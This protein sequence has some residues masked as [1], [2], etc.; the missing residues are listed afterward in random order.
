MILAG[1]AWKFTVSRHRWQSANKAFRAAKTLT[2]AP[3][4]AMNFPGDWGLPEEREKS[5]LE[6]EQKFSGVNFTELE[7]RL[8]Q[9]GASLLGQQVEVDQYLN[10][11]DRDFAITKEAFRL[12]RVGKDAVLTYKGPKHPG[13]VKIRTELEVF[14]ADGQDS[15]DDCLTLLRCLGY[16]PVAV[17]RKTRRVFRIEHDG[18]SISVCLDDVGDVGQFAEIEVLAPDDR[19][20]T[21][22]SAVTGMAVELGLQQLERRSYLSLYLAKTQKGSS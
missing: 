4:L 16:R 2:L 9:L 3:C 8:Y 7:E 15:A 14:L 18:L 12:R 11:P 10:A 13:A 6:I 19:L 17:V 5:M 21:A 22:R 20:D 1:A